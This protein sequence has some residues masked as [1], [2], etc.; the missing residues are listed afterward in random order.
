MILPD[1][2]KI[3]C[4]PKEILAKYGVFDKDGC[5]IGVKGNAPV[6]FK[7]AY[8]DYKK[9]REEMEALGIE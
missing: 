9:Y 5:I 2:A 8:D 1:N 4:Y 6:D 3:F 7:S